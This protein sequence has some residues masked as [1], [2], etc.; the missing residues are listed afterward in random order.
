MGGTQKTSHQSTQSVNFKALLESGRKPYKDPRTPIWLGAQLNTH[1]TRASLISRTNRNPRIFLKTGPGSKWSHP[2]VIVVGRR[3]ENFAFQAR[4]QDRAVGVWGW[5]RERSGPGGQGS[6]KTHD[7]PSTSSCPMCPAQPAQFSLSVQLSLAQ[8]I[9]RDRENAIRA[10]ADMFLSRCLEPSS[11]SKWDCQ[12]R[13]W[14][15]V[16]DTT[17]FLGFSDWQETGEEFVKP[18]VW[19]V[20]ETKFGFDQIFTTEWFGGFIVNV[21]VFNLVLKNRSH[22]QDDFSSL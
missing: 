9:V 3:V 19:Q 15:N 17:T 14:C 2:N 12:P 11:S 13:V 7:L 20:A 16:F 6:S 10:F 5:Q 18:C 1:P 8:V 22:G 21:S 4:V